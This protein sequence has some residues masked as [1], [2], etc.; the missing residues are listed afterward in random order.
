MSCRA[1]PV[2]ASSVAR[3]D[4]H[5]AVT[6]AALTVLDGAVATGLMVDVVVAAAVLDGVVLGTAIVVV[7]MLFVPVAGLTADVAR[8]ADASPFRVPG[9]EH[10]AASAMTAAVITS[11]LGSIGAGETLPAG[12]SS[13]VGTHPAPSS[14]SYLEIASTICPV[15]SAG[16]ASGGRQGI[17][18]RIKA[19]LLSLRRRRFKGSG[20]YWEDR[21]SRGGNSGAGSYGELARSKAD[22]LNRLV[23][24]NGYKSVL[25]LGCGDGNQL[26]L[27]RY[28]SY[29]GV[30]ISSTAIA[31][32]RDRF[33]ADP[34]K[35]FIV[36]GEEPI[37]DC[38]LGL[39][40]DVIYHLVED[41]VFESYMAD[42][43]S[44][45]TKAVVLYT[46]DSDAFVPEGPPPAHIRHRAVQRWMA[47]RSGW[48]LVQRIPNAYPFNAKQADLTSFA[49]FYV[50]RRVP[51][52]SA[53]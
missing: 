17:S 31:N 3:F 20:S 51:A 18:G 22:V 6:A 27:A 45:S 53:G 29:V 47:E 13:F 49:D 32:C 28:E 21:Y 26:S 12:G 8:V 19:S 52:T 16:A 24:E 10:P 44:H 40:L 35:R 9:L 34:T 1:R 41:D 15:C 33:G 46:S 38:E 7:G 39:S 23:A 25:E 43:L 37:P 30:D 50:Y 48:E 14:G 4:G 42:L 36:H 2:D 11:F 5:G